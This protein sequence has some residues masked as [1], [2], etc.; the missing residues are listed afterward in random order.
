MSK[1][2]T[3]NSYTEEKIQLRLA[4]LPEKKELNIL[5]CYRGNSVL[6]DAVKKRT[7][8]KLNIIGIDKRRDYEGLYL[9][10]DNLKFLSN[11]DLSVFDIIDLDA[12][13]IPYKQLE[14]IFLKNYKGVVLVTFIQSVMGNI[15]KKLLLRL[16]YTESMY[17]KCQTLLSRNGYEKF[18]SYLFLNGIC[19]VNSVNYN[20]KHYL[21]FKI[22]Q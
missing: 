20:N 15:N 5:D 3:N 10:G 4:A 1:V 19:E 7:S 2:Q 18:K 12:Y 13:G 9:Q 6:W 16:G 14:M 17:R 11:F 22:N 8:K 21:F